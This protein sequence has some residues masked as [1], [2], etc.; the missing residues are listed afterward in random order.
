METVTLALFGVFVATLVIALALMLS[1]GLSLW[2]SWWTYPAWAWFV[3]PATGFSPIG[4]WMY[5]GLMMLLRSKP[6]HESTT[7]IPDDKRGW[8]EKHGSPILAA[9]L[10]APLTWLVLRW[11][12]GKIAI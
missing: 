1:V 8:F 10:G 11:I 5:V 7:V 6:Y 4:F 2:W 3:M 12:H 9:L